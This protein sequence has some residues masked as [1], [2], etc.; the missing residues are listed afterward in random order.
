MRSQVIKNQ[1]HSASQSVTDPF[2][3]KLYKI[4]DT[5]VSP[6]I[7]DNLLNTDKINLISNIKQHR[8]SYFFLPLD[9]LSRN[10]QKITDTLIE[11][12]KPFQPLVIRLA[13]SHPSECTIELLESLNKLA[14]QGACLYN[15]LHYF[16]QIHTNSNIIK[17]L[18]HKLLMMRVRPHSIFVNLHNKTAEQKSQIIDSSKA[19]LENLRGWTS[20]LAVPHLIA[21][22]NFNSYQLNLPNYII[23]EN[24]ENFVFRNYKN[25]KF[26][27]AN[28]G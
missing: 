9:F 16:N 15:H 5:E 4:F 17:E 7:E 12:L 28:K 21:H 6:F 1:F 8:K 22:D 27:Y 18:N 14:N 25:L 23:K 26:D 13:I 19:I 2:L 24:E 10:P 3:Q 11:S 20:G